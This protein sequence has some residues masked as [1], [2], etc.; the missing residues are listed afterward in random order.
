MAYSL[1]DGKTHNDISPA[2]RDKLQHLPQDAAGL[3]PCA[4]HI[5]GVGDDDDVPPRPPERRSACHLSTTISQQI[6]IFMLHTDTDGSL[7]TMAIFDQVQLL[8]Q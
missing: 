1:P 4:E 8:V 7:G 3:G 2:A 6:T 5:A